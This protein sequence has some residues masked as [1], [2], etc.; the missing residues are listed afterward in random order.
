MVMASSITNVYGRAWPQRV[1]GVSFNDGEEDTS[2]AVVAP[3]T[4][5]PREE[6]DGICFS[7]TLPKHVDTR[8][9]LAFA[10]G[11]LTA[12]IILRIR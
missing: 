2:A 7:I 4:H 3:T 11:A 8:L 1:L 12:M 9:I 5:V 10:A 6:E